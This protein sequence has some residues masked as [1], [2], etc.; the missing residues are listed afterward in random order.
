MHRTNPLQAVF[1]DVGGTLWPNAG[2][3]PTPDAVERRA[4]LR[5]DGIRSLWPELDQQAIDDFIDRLLAEPDLRMDGPIRQ[6]VPGALERVAS[7]FGLRCESGADPV[8]AAL[9]IPALGSFEPF[10]GAA[11]LLGLIAKRRWSAAVLSNAAIRNGALYARDFA[12][13]GWHVPGLLF[14]T[15]LDVGYRKP[16]PA[17]FQAALARLGVP[18][19]AVVVIGDSE[20]ND[21]EPA[22]QL[23]MKAIRVAIE[24][25]LDHTVADATAKSLAEVARLLENWR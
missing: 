9:C 24:A 25:D 20:R 4:E 7:A 2:P 3:P 8:L 12:D 13:M 19:D 17:M 11:E 1:L 14:L 23:G 16:H 15:S 22:R 5:R 18:S 6:D 21:I 10:E